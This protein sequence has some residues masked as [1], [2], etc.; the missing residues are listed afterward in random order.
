MNVNECF[1]SCQCSM[2]RS[3]G[4]RPVTQYSS[5]WRALYIR[6][7]LNEHLVVCI[8]Q[9]YYRMTHQVEPNLELTSK[10]KFRFGLVW[11]GLT[12]S[13]QNGTFV[14]MSGGLTQP[15][16]SPYTAVCMS[17]WCMSWS[18]ILCKRTSDRGDYKQVF[19]PS[20]GSIFNNQQLVIPLIP[21]Y[22]SHFCPLDTKRCRKN[23]TLNIGRNVF[24]QNVDSNSSNILCHRD[25]DYIDSFT[26]TLLFTVHAFQFSIY[27]L[28]KELLSFYQCSKFQMIVECSSVRI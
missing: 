12:W 15:D 20:F 26:S 25:R 24:R 22:L 7:T 10:Q 19:E 2:C 4:P 16:V 1:P 28:H 18:L 5:Q 27:F 14:L 13:G 8:E 3:V 23:C 9:T 17:C 6:M 11:P 21:T